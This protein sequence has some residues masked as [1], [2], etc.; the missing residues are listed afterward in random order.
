[1]GSVVGVLALQGDFREHKAALK[2][3]GL[4]AKEVRKVKDLEG[5]K[6]LIVPGG[7]S[8][9]IGKLAREYG[10]EEAVRR[11]VEEGTL[12]LFGTCAGAIWLAREILGYPEQ[13]RLGVL[14][15]AVERNAFG[16]Q[17]E[18]FEEDLE[19]EG[20]GSFHGV[21]IRAPVFRRLGEGVEVLA[22]LGDLP[23]LVRQGKVLASSFHPELTE[24][25]RLHRY[26]LEL[27]GV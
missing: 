7:E 27:A 4:E 23:V 22:R 18:S 1:M 2:R 25:P 5:L 24:D 11:R 20:L 17:V 13:P 6:A 3:L 10:L 15:A 12:A 8:T 19:V 14:D 9:T 16:R 21:F 26:F